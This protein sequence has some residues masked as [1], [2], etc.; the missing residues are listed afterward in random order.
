MNQTFG[1]MTW[2]AKEKQ[3]VSKLFVRTYTEA[4]RKN[5]LHAEG[6]FPNLRAGLDFFKKHE[7]TFPLIYVEGAGL[8]TAPDWKSIWIE[9]KAGCPF[10]DFVEYKRSTEEV[11]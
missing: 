2:D 3:W 11:K 8:K 5:K 7:P 4:G 9:G 10:V 1:A 6:Q